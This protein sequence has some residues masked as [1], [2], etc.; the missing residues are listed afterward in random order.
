MWSRKNNNSNGEEHLKCQ[1][2]GRK[3]HTV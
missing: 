2:C 1:L 3:G